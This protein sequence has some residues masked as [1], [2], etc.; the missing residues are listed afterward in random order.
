MAQSCSY[1]VERGGNARSFHVDGMTLGTLVP[2]ISANVARESAVMT[3]AASRYKFLKENT[4]VASH[5]TVN[6]AEDEYV[7]AGYI[8]T[9]TVAL[10]AQSDRGH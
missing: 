8:H 10:S 7:R 1:P 3:D 2:I 9:N 5:D 6:H 4:C